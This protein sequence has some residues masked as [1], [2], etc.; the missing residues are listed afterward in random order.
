MGGYHDGE[1]TLADDLAGTLREGML[2]L[3]GA[4]VSH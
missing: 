1:N 4:A 2:N 3:A